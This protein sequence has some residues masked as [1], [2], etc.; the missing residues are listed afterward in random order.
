MTSRLSRLPEFESL[1]F[2]NDGLCFLQNCAQN[3]AGHVGLR[4]SD[5]PRMIALSAGLRR[6]AKRWLSSTQVGALTIS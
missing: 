5:G 4:Q 1:M 6:R 3:E 2:V